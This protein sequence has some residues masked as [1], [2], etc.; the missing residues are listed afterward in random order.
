MINATNRNDSPCEI[1][2][3]LIKHH[4][5]DALVNLPEKCWTV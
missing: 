5:F 2:I 4:S 1:I 3:I